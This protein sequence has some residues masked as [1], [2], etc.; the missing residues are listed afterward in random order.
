MKVDGYISRISVGG[1]TYAL[2]TEVV[3]AKPLTCSKCG[4]SLILR[5]GEGQCEH[6]G[7]YYSSHITIEETN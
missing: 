4:A 7:T 3:I 6:C 1:K 2:K 5:Y